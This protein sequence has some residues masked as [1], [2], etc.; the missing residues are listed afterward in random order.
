[1][2]CPPCRQKGGPHYSVSI[3]VT[4]AVAARHKRFMRLSSIGP[5]L[6]TR[7]RLYMGGSV[8]D[9]KQL[10]LILSSLPD[11]VL[12][13]PSPFKNFA[14]PKYEISK[15]FHTCVC[16]HMSSLSGWFLFVLTLSSHL[17]CPL[18]LR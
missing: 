8:G 5:Q 14:K 4:L 11:F 18:H 9:N 15:P 1:M 13:R 6:V 17:S 16:P 2:G 3:T 12:A 7:E 10:V